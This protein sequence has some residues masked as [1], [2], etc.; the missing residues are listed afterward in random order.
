M[1]KSKKYRKKQ[2]GY[3][4]K[5]ANAPNLL[6]HNRHEPIGIGYDYNRLVNIPIAAGLHYENNRRKDLEGL[7]ALKRVQNRQDHMDRIGIAVDAE[8]AYN[9]GVRAAVPQTMG[10]ILSGLDKKEKKG[11]KAAHASKP[12]GVDSEVQTIKEPEA[13]NTLAL[14]EL[15]LAT[16]L[17]RDN[18]F[19]YEGYQRRLSRA[20][21]RPA[22][23]PP[24]ASPGTAPRQQLDRDIEDSTNQKIINKDVVERRRD[25]TA[26]GF[27]AERT[28]QPS[29]LDRAAKEGLAA[30]TIQRAVKERAERLAAEEGLAAETIQRAINERAERLAAEEADQLANAQRRKERK[31]RKEKQVSSSPPKYLAPLILPPTTTAVG[32]LDVARGEVLIKP[33]AERT[34]TT[35]YHKGK[36]LGKKIVGAMTPGGGNLEPAYKVPRGSPNAG[37]LPPPTPTREERAEQKHKN[38]RIKATKV[39]RPAFYNTPTSGQS[40]DISSPTPDSTPRLVRP[41]L[42]GKK[43]DAVKNPFDTPSPES[44]EVTQPK[45]LRRKLDD[46]LDESIARAANADRPIDFEGE[47]KAFLEDLSDSD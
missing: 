26:Q 31:E 47:M 1:P 6:Q 4:R 24:P 30:E 44:H 27:L 3:K 34:S 33:G 20:A 46:K 15:A 28:P 40:R 43:K 10:Q 32:D 19:T 5:L 23:A 8:K 11:K 21:S 9:F 39:A 25:L 45:Q 36:N 2:R 37:W 29:S 7:E 18:F 22:S 42:G 16:P 17:T 12:K 38:R 41:I 14:E 13:D 35:V